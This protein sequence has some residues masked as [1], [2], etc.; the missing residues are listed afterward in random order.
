MAATAVWADRFVGARAGFGAK[1]EAALARPAIWAAA[2]A[3]VLLL[4]TVLTV[5][6]RPWLDEYQA[7]QIAMQSPDLT[8]LAANLRYEGHPPLWYLML[9]LAG[10]V[11]PT[12]WVLPLVALPLALTIQLTILLR[13]PFTRLERLMIATSEFVL[14]EYGV[15]SRS[16]TLGVA[17]L[18]LAFAFRD[19]RWGWLPLA[20]L[21]MA[22]FLYGALSII[23]IFIQHRERRFWLP[24]FLAWGIV[25][26][27]AA[28][29]VRPAPDVVPAFSPGNLVFEA[30]T[31]LNRLSIMLLPVQVG[32]GRLAWNNPL[33]PGLASIAGPLF[34]VFAVRQLRADRFGLALWAGFAALTLGFSLLCYPLAIRHLSLVALL[35]ILLRWR[36]AEQGVIP[37]AAFRWWLAGL[38]ACG[39]LNAG[40]ALS[41][42]FDTAP[43]AAAAIQQLGIAD[44]HWVSFPDSQ[45]QGISA[46]L[47]TKF[48]RLGR[49]CAQDFIRWNVRSQVRKPAQLARALKRITTRYGRVYLLSSVPLETTIPTSLARLI[50]AIPAG[51]DGQEYHLYTVGAALPA[52]SKRPPPCVSGQRPLR[53]RG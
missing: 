34:L 8:G 11:V 48:D 9:R 29:S 13:A 15:L 1:L 17:L 3:A 53:W 20:L 21:P 42:P 27:L 31:W 26:L 30:G 4:Q 51:Y 50:A 25:A 6:H 33:P 52:S 14:F 41:Q 16:L 19:R 46:L 7:L 32:D 44:A 28:W 10:A 35:L 38:A 45:G 39:L 37:D 24:G 22:D 36:A 5:T 2:V 23:L 40:V 43:E 49:D 12:A 18:L 47:G